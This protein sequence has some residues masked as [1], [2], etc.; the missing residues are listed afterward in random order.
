MIKWTQQSES[1]PTAIR[2]PSHPERA[3]GN[4]GKVTDVAAIFVRSEHFVSV[5]V[6]DALAVWCP[7]RIMRE[8]VADL[9][10][11]AA[12]G[13]SN[14]DGAFSFTSHLVLDEQPLA[15]RRDAF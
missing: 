14:P 7:A 6:Q 2:R 5:R 4:R 11:A 3:S 1:Q 15:I 8:N 12:D 13:R 9:L 10:R